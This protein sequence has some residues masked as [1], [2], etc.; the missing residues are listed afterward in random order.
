M[1]KY[2]FSI[3]TGTGEPGDIFIDGTVRYVC[4]GG[5]SAFNFDTTT[6]K[7]IDDT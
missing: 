3:V 6:F 5:V 2:I 1:P 4:D 7:V